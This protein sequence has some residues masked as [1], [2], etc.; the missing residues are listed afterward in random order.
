MTSYIDAVTSGAGGLK[1]AGDAS[2]TLELKSGGVTQATVGPSGLSLA[3]GLT[4]PDGSAQ[5]RGGWQ[6]LAAASVPSNVASLDFTGIPSSVKALR[7][8]F[9]LVP[10]TNGVQLYG[11]FSQSGAFVSSANYAYNNLFAGSGTDVSA[12]GNAGSAT[13]WNF[14]PG[15]GVYNIATSAAAAGI[16][17]VIDFTDIQ[18]PRYVT[19]VASYHQ[20]HTG[21]GTSYAISGSARLTLAG[22]ID[23]FQ[24]FFSGGNISE[25]RAVLLALK[26]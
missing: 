18:T 5:S 25:G 11:R 7:L 23:G 12:N 9:D 2:G 6:R 20:F 1:A 21:N 16:S 14:N 4:W 15:A 24:L 17:G 3:T 8:I 26:E 10:A 13:V 19:A 22:P